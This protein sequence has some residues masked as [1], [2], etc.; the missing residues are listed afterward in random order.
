MSQAK[1]VHGNRKHDWEAILSLGTL[2]KRG[3][4][5]V[6]T[7]IKGKHYTCRNYA[8]VQQARNNVDR[9]KFVLS[10]RINEK[11]DPERVVMTITRK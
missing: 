7:L 9:S 5:R 6:V 1:R 10:T 3:D 11:S 2:K 4:S 8:I